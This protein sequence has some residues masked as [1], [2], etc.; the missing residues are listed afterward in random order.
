MG[1]ADDVLGR[2]A[3]CCNPVPGDDVVGF[4]TRGRGIAIHLRT[5]A[6]VVSSPEPERL[7]D[8]DWGADHTESHAVDVEIRV[9][10]RAGVM[11]ELSKLVSAMGVNINSARADGNQGGAAWIR[12]G[13]DCKS[14]DQVALVIERIDRHPEVLEVRRLRGR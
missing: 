2:R 4:V 11:G 12:L 13:L 3:R 7:V 8:I 1:G 9:H 6:H 10:D 5:C 14:A